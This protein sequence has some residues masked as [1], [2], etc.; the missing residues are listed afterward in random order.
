MKAST[1]LIEARRRSGLSRRGMAKSGGTSAATLA[2]YESGHT[3]PS[4]ETLKRLIEAAGFDIQ[5]SLRPRLPEDEGARRAKIET[6]L[7][8]TDSLPRQRR[9][10]R[11]PGKFL[12]SPTR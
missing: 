11:I 10:D 2:D 9:S 3:V 6:L 8:F 7:R 12:V 1:L 4:V 5:V